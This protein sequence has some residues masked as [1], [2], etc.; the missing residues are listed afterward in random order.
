MTGR[1][2]QTTGLTNGKAV[3][4]APEVEFRPFPS[5]TDV[6]VLLLNQ[7]SVLLQRLGCYFSRATVFETLPD[8]LRSHSDVTTSFIA[9]AS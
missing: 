2:N 7:P 5:S 8:C 4:L 9:Q 1:A 3:N 6:P